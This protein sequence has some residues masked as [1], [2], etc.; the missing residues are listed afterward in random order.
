M[1]RSGN[2]VDV[3]PEHRTNPHHETSRVTDRMR[4]IIISGLV[5]LVIGSSV[6]GFTDVPADHKYVQDIRI[7]K[8]RGIFAGYGD[9]TFGP[10]D[11]LTEQQMSIVFKRMFTTD[12]GDFQI[13]RGE[14]AA[15]MVA[16]DDRL[17]DRNPTVCNVTTDVPS[18][19]NSTDAGGQWVVD[20]TT[21]TGNL[22]WVPDTTTTT[23]TTT[24]PCSGTVTGISNHRDI[25]G[26]CV[27]PDYFR[28]CPTGYHT[29]D[30][31]HGA[32]HKNDH[33]DL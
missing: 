18:S 14:A 13:T 25:A 33:S 24:L 28:H 26:N 27:K 22:V 3:E 12:N 21:G 16:G 15:F 7:A 20:Q 23:T 11:R 30:R 32:C 2:L 1:L 19:G 4:N 5:G 17:E 8:A 9:G 29:H 31:S 10:D 6:S